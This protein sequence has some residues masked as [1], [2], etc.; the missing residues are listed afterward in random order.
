MRELMRLCIRS[1]RYTIVAVLSTLSELERHLVWRSFFYDV[2]SSLKE[3]L[4][5]RFCSTAFKL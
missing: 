2:L 4:I 5:Y 3:L 1:Q